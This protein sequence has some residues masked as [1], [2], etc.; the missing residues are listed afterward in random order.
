MTHW[1]IKA[2]SA[3]GGTGRAEWAPSTVYSVGDR[4][5]CRRTYASTTRRRWVYECTT[6]GTS[7]GSTEPVWPT[8]S[9]VNDNGVI[10]TTRQPITWINASIYLDYIMGVADWTWAAGDYFWV[11][12]S[13]VTELTGILS[14][15]NVNYN[16]GNY[17]IPTYITSTSDLTHEPPTSRAVGAK[18]RSTSYC[19]PAA[20]ALHFY[21]CIFEVGYG[22]TSGTPHF[23]TVNGNNGWYSG[24]TLENCKI[25]L[26]YAVT[27]CYV[28][29]GNSSSNFAPG[30][31][32][33]IDTDIEFTHAGQ[34]IAVELGRSTMFGG[35]ILGVPPTSLFY[36]VVHYLSGSTSIIGVDLS[37]ASTN[38][39]NVTN[40]QDL[41]LLISR[42][43]LNSSVNAFTGTLVSARRG[44]NIVVELCSAGTANYKMAVYD[45]A[46]TVVDETARVRT[47][48]ASDGTTPIAWK[49]VSTAN[50]CFFALRTPQIATWID[51]TGVEKTLT[52][53]ILHDSVTAL[54]DDEVWLEAVVLTNANYPQALIVTDRGVPVLGGTAQTSSS[55]T[56]YTVGMAN[57]NRQ[58]LSVVVTP[59]MK[60]FVTAKVY[61]AKPNYTVYV[62][63][64]I[65]VS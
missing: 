17:V 31:A 28:Y 55:E 22:A 62:D 30:E 32:R 48:G 6:G 16:E 35:A 44:A 1:Y 56:W 21:G 60:G 58:K 18:F 20:S 24:I 50:N 63:P 5:V 41:S 23:Y 39:I 36:G 10:W 7:H 13:L 40:M 59:Q 43:K 51:E 53:E 12:N 57:P 4:V 45:F 38:L 49:M 19:E 11:D 46:G 9:T 3:M 37:N 34:G 2:P 42:C 54:K 65:V 33:L 52:V 25:K 47:G 15:G 26:A 27:G 8:S 14:L 29:Y 64:K 61:F